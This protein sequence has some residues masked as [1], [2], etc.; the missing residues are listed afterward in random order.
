MFKM[1][2]KLAP[3]LAKATYHPII[4]GVVVGVAVVQIDKAIDRYE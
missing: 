4:T 3:M 1:F 2:R